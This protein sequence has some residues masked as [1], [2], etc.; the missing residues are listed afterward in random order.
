MVVPCEEVSRF[1]TDALMVVET[2]Q[3][4]AQQ[5][6]DVLLDA[7]CK[8]HFSHGVNRLECYINDIRKKLCDPNAEPVVLKETPATA[9]VDG[10]NGFGPVVGNFCMNLA[11]SKAK[12][13]GVGWVAAKGSNHYGIA[14]WYS[15][16]AL[17]HGLLGM[18]FTNGSPLISPTRGKKRA[19]GTNPITLAAPA[20]GGDSFVLDMATAVVA[21]G[22]VE[23]QERKGELLPHG[24]AQDSE[25]HLTTDPKLVKNG[26]L[27]PLGGAEETSG[28]KGYGLSLMSDTFAG[29]LAGASFGPFVRH[30]LDDQDQEPN[31]GQGFVAIDPQ[32]FAPGFEDRMAQLLDYLRNMEPADPAKPVLVPGDPERINMKKVEE[33]GGISYHKNQLAAM[34]V[35]AKEL[36]IRP[37]QRKLS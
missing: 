15:R 23:I 3:D 5:L 13:V 34:D 22:K 11:I 30:W 12:N 33:E 19:L 8:G 29:L 14:G 37:L 32:C 6:A 25:G 17:K 1:I 24:W 28:Y 10:N 4:H 35:L 18:S 21:M 2:R 9:W 36:G 7:D 26:S 20:T 27:L 31:L 16:L